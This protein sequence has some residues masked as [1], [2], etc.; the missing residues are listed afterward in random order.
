MSKI[1]GLFP[2][3]TPDRDRETDTDG[4]WSICVRESHVDGGA[5]PANELVAV[6]MDG[7][8]RVEVLVRGPDCV[9][10]P[11]ISPASHALNLANDTVAKASRAAASAASL[12][13]AVEL[14]SAFLNITAE[15]RAPS[16]LAARPLA[17]AARACFGKC[18]PRGGRSCR[19]DAS[20]FGPGSR[21]TTRSG[22]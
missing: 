11:R 16:G 3:K 2:R 15:A 9:A 5:E 10:S 17:C 13:A 7:S 19:L 21:R 8:L 18:Q 12:D 14:R 6:A 1:K 20:G 22:P 4:Q